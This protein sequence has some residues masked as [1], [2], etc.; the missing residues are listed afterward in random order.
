MTIL[1]LMLGKKRGGLEQ[2]ALDYA[3][4]LAM[5]G[6]PALTIVSPGAW[7]EPQ[8]ANAKVAHESLIAR[9]NWD[10][11]AVLRLRALAKRTQATSVICHGNRAISLALQALSGRIP[12]IAVAHNYSTR[13]FAKADACFAI[14]RHLKEHLATN[15]AQN[16]FI[17]PNMVRL[18]EARERPHFRTPPVLGSMGRFVAKKG[19]KHYIEALS[20]LRGR[21]V[22]FRAILGGEGEEGEAIA[23][24]ITR[25]QLQDVVTLTGWVQNKAAFFDAL[26]IFVLPSMME[27]FGIVLIEAMSYGIPVVSTEAHGPREII[28]QGVDGILFQSGD[29]EAM[30]DAMEQLVT[31][32]ARAGA[33][34][35]AG[36]ALVAREYTMHA[37]ADRL[38]AALAAYI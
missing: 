30:A 24:L 26:D 20:I 3:E 10:L 32:P 2:A 19:F 27:A 22:A 1:N 25:Y 18:P 11:F 29:R 28:H 14:T 17:M 12:V 37:M 34:G 23:E 31:D 16:I 8:L 38:K 6:L 15:G 33:I 4:S 36:A 7:I 21:G 9:G 13:R 5:A 35:R